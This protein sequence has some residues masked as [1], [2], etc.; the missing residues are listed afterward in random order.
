MRIRTLLLPE[1]NVDLSMRQTNF[2]LTKINRVRLL[3][4]TSNFLQST[5]IQSL[6]CR[7]NDATSSLERLR[8]SKLNQSDLTWDYKHRTRRAFYC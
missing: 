5:E 7:S 8:R 2:G 6:L 4:Q 3:C 1:P